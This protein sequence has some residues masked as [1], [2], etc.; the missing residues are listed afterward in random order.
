MSEPTYEFI[1]GQGWVAN[2]LPP[3]CAIRKHNGKTYRVTILDRP[4]RSGER[5]AHL[6]DKPDTVEWWDPWY[7]VPAGFGP[8]TSVHEWENQRY[9]SYRT[10]IT[11]LIE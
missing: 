1:K 11:E 3:N 8:C 6:R 2:G 9:A 7:H 10:V 5:Y 4:P